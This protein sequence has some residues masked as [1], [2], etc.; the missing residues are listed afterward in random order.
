MYRNHSTV[1]HTMSVTYK[2]ASDESV[3][4]KYRVEV[5]TLS[6]DEDEKQKEIVFLD[7]KKIQHAANKR[8]SV[9]LKST[10]QKENTHCK[11][12]DDYNIAMKLPINTSRKRCVKN[13]AANSSKRLVIR[14]DTTPYIVLDSSDEEKDAR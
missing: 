1:R 7:Q 2:A 13:P 8:P 3:T 6:D 11:W 12:M 4:T 5:V 9:Q 14:N 10:T